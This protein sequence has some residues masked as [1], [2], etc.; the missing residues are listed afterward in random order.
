MQY[1]HFVPLSLALALCA[2][3]SHAATGRPTV[4]VPTS[5]KRADFGRE[6]PSR[7][8]RQVVNDVVAS[9]DNEG[10]HFIVLDKVNARVYVFEPGGRLL[11][12]AP[13]LLGLA[14]G[15]D[16]VPGIGDKKIADIKP[17]ERT[18]PA[19]RFVA[20]MGQSSSRGED[21]VWVDY[22]SAVSM[23]RV[24]TSNPKE[25][26]LQRLATRTAKDNR[27]SY[28]CINLPKAFYEKWVGPTVAQS[29]TI[30]YV[31]PET[32][33]PREVFGFMEASRVAGRQAPA[34]SLRAGPPEGANWPTIDQ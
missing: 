6:Q 10:A 11:A 32:R 9:G 29:S 33:S 5:V 14:H 18:T 3:V 2:T 22:D 26:R 17:E 1:K 23:H 4:S 13:A 8:A 34:R 25:R 16:T 7:D 15:D 27:I 30:I 28:G 21:V 20:E 31:L 12:A 24:V 19:G